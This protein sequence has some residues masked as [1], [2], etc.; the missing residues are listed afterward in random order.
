M[1]NTAILLFKGNTNTVAPTN[2]KTIPSTKHAINP[3]IRVDHS[4]DD[5]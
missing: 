2:D 5:I 3:L 4:S 1:P